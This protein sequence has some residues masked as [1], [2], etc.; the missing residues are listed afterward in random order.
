MKRN[1]IAGDNRDDLELKKFQYDPDTRKSFVNIDDTGI[2]EAINNVTDAMSEIEIKNDVGNPVPISATSLPL[3]TGA[4]TAALQAIVNTN[5]NNTVAWAATIAGNNVNGQNKTR[6]VDVFGAEIVLQTGNV[7]VVKIMN[8]G[9]NNG[10]I[11]V[12]TTAVPA[13]TLGVNLANRKNLVIYNNGTATIY[14]GYDPALTS[15]SGIPLAIGQVTSL[16]V[17][18]NTTIYLIAASGSHNVRIAEG[19]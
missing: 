19:S 6:I 3:P 2:I 13:R 7:P 11:T 4:A 8:N 18:S 9:G 10:P 17:G 5:T 15:N 16:D 1:P 12:S 14:W